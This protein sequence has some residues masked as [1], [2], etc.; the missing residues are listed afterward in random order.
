[1]ASLARHILICSVIVSGSPALAG[2]IDALYSAESVE[3]KADAGLFTLLL[4]VNAMGWDEA[5][6]TGP[7]PL[8]RPIYDPL[9]EDVRGKLFKYR[10]RY[11]SDG[12]MREFEDFIT[13]HAQP[14]SDYIAYVATLGP[15]PHFEPTGPAPGNAAKL[16]GLEKLIAKA[17]KQGRLEVFMGRFRSKLVHRMRTFMDKLDKETAQLAVLFTGAEKAKADSDKADSGDSLEDLFG[18]EGGDEESGGEA[19]VT[20]NFEA[21]SAAITPTWI[22]GRSLTLR[23]GDRVVIV[24]GGHAGTAVVLEELVL[25]RLRGWA[26]VGDA[27]VQP[28]QRAAALAV[29]HFTG[30]VSS[31]EPLPQTCRETLSRLSKEKIPLKAPGEASQLFTSCS[32]KAPQPQ[33]TD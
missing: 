20:T 6:K 27:P 16:K 1:M 31:K 12:V 9:R 15:A 21:V 5:A 22:A 32:P 28:E 7:A 13:G 24:L 2:G 25:S 4:V 18:D 11:L 30:L 10:S 3:V 19:D 8:S 33:E 14:L 26:A 17:W 23:V 29:L